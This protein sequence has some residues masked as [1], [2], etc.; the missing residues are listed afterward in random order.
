MTQGPIF[1][2]LI[3]YV[4]PLIIAN[5]LQ[6]VFNLTDTLVLGVFAENGNLCVGAVATTGAL[7]SLITNLFIGLSTGANVMVARYIGAKKDESVKKTIGVAVFLSVVAGAILVLVGVFCSRHFLTLTGVSDLHIDLA[8]RYITI[9]L[10]GAP[11]IMLYNYCANVLRASG[12]T[13]RPMLYI[14]I[15]GVIN[16]VLNIV[17][18]VLTPLDVEGVAI[19]TVVSNAFAGIACFITLLKGQSS[20]K[21]EWKY[22]RIFKEEF[23]ELLK[24]GVPSGINGCLF[25]FSN[26]LIV[27]GTN[28]LGK[29]FGNHIVTGAGYANQIDNIIY[30]CMNAVALSSQAFVSQNL[31][32]RKYERIKRSFFSSLGIVSVVGV[33]LGVLMICIAKPLF[34]AIS[35]SQLVAKAT[36]TKT[37]WVGL[38]Y[39]LA[40]LMEVMSCSLRG[41][42][43]SFTGMIVTLSGTVL[44]RALWVWFIFPL[45]KTEAMLYCLYPISW[46]ITVI[47]LAIILAVVFRNLRRRLLTASNDAKIIKEESTN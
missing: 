14:T 38:F 8:T 27:S 13:V 15:G 37:F 39:V 9:Y 30:V 3:T 32:A 10:C 31:G 28:E 47:T 7:I 24:V 19:A 6:M 45:K 29:I 17:L 41:L 25:A 5:L 21:F 2:Q 22:F 44:F 46:I 1:K 40:G 36:F 26:V 23:I 33:S 34:T 42:G 12:D 11:F 18:V 20:V 35:G 4:I 16:V 43:K